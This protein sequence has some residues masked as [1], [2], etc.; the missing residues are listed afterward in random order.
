MRSDEAAK[1][2]I[3]QLIRVTVQQSEARVSPVYIVGAGKDVKSGEGSDPLAGPPRKLMMMVC[4]DPRPFVRAELH[5][6]K[7][8]VPVMTKIFGSKQSDRLLK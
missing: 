1:T 8:C 3:L 5:N 4:A 7:E 2:V 6:S